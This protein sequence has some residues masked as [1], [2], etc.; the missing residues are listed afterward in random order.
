MEGLT[1]L[2]VEQ[3]SVVKKYPK[4]AATFA[5]LF[6]AGAGMP[7]RWPSAALFSNAT[8]RDALTYHKAHPSAI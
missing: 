5:V 6:A 1:L 3:W 7:V 8:R 2:N 4:R